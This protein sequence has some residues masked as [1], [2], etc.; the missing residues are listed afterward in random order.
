MPKFRVGQRVIASHH[1]GSWEGN[2][3][4]INDTGDGIEYE[5]SDSPHDA[6]M[7]GYLRSFNYPLLWEEELTAVNEET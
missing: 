7:S 5:V 1:L 4:L 2:V 3:L 6:L